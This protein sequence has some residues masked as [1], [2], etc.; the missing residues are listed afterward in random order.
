M[1]PRRSL[2]EAIGFGLV[3]T[4]VTAVLRWEDVLHGSSALPDTLMRR[5]QLRDFHQGQAW[6]DLFQHRLGTTGVSIHWSRTWD[7][8]LSLPIWVLEPFIGYTN[9]EQVAVVLLPAVT[10]LSSLIV[11]VALVRKLSGSNAALPAIVL[12]LLLP[13]TYSRA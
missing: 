7:L 5:V 8:A 6:Y 12:F 4:A 9:A 3:F 10:L 2:W 1:I 11:I 13:F